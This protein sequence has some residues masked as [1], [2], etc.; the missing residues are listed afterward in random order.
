[1]SL[2][3]WCAPGRSTAGRSALTLAA[4]MCLSA[5]GCCSQFAFNAVPANRLP[6]ELQGESR[7]CKVPIDFSLLR[8]SQPEAYRLGPGDVLTLYVQDVLPPTRETL[9]LL[10][11]TFA[12]NPVYYPANGLVD[13]PA[14]GVPL[15]VRNDGTL[16]LPGST[17]LRVVGATLEE[18]TE[19]V[20]K[21]ITQDKKLVVPGR[22]QIILSLL[23]PRTTRVLVLRDD[24]EAGNQMI[25]TVRREETLLARRGTA[26]A[27]DLPAY[28]NDVLHAI[29]TTGGLPGV[30]AY[31]DVWVLHGKQEDF[32]PTRQ[33]IDA[34]DSPAKVMSRY[35]AT[36]HVVKIP[37]RVLPGEPVPFG[38]DDVLLQ[39]GDIVY[40]ETRQT[41]FFYSGGLLPG[42]Q[43][44]L[45]RDYDLDVIGAIAL[46]NG[47]VAGPAGQNAATVLNVRSGPGNIV[48][49]TRVIILRTLPDGEQVK[50][51]VDLN[52]AMNNPKERVRILPGDVVMLNYK[53]HE[54]V[55]NTLLNLVNFNLSGI[56]TK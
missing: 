37:L 50:I 20:R 23:R 15:T 17:Q 33:L 19:A 12:P 44:P 24:A 27:V 32:A 35:G 31:S 14:V 28:E 41:E 55:Q 11:G 48:P 43:I 10:Q 30:D 34:G 54:V 4:A 2:R 45:P 36:H 3:S 6:L 53:P 49:P 51:R 39:D 26:A 40:I 16:P 9:P 38:P 52:C 56:F 47:S 29:L 1:M 13:T 8:L 46:A 21:A 7:S 25:R 22:E 42:G 18:A 5:A